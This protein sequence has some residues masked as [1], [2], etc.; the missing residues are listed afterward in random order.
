MPATEEEAYRQWEKRF[1]EKHSLGD[2]QTLLPT[3]SG[4]EARNRILALYGDAPL[5]PVV[6]SMIEYY[7][8]PKNIANTLLDFLPGPGDLKSGIEAI[9]GKSGL[10]LDEPMAWWQRGLS[11]LG[12]LP[13]IPNIAGVIRGAGKSDELRGLLKAGK[14]GDIP[15]TETPKTPEGGKFISKS[16]S[17]AGVDIEPGLTIYHGSQGPIGGEFDLNHVGKGH[18][19]TEGWGVYFASDKRNANKF[20]KHQKKLWISVDDITKFLDEDARLSEQSPYVRDSLQ[21]FLQ[22]VLNPEDSDVIQRAGGFVK[23]TKLT[24]GLSHRGIYEQISGLQWKPKELIEYLGTIPDENLRKYISKQIL[25]NPDMT[26]SEIYRM[27]VAEWGS[28]RRA[29]LYLKDLGIPGKIVSSNNDLHSVV[30]D[31]PNF[32]IWDESLLNKKSLP[33]PSTPAGEVK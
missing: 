22:S 2:K 33:K 12:A 31:S 16:L 7:R 9:A 20:G 10:A 29:S 21:K 14:K 6:N 32:V 5:E 27:M 3:V 30:L 26:G 4:E 8:D 23:N 13:M 11:G 25:G 19:T 28:E 1:Y 15:T 24:L 17:K 18:A